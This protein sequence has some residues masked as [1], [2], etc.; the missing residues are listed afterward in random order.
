MKSKC[1]EQKR[2]VNFVLVLLAKY[3]KFLIIP[4]RFLVRFAQCS[5][6]CA[7]C[8]DCVAMLYVF[9]KII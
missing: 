2:K 5:V 8:C 7:V 3:K 1:T 9:D 4:R 6:M